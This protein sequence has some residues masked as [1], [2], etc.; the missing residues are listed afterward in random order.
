MSRSGFAIFTVIAAT[1]VLG[2]ISGRSVA[3]HSK[4][5]A[6]STPGAIIANRNSH[7]MSPANEVTARPESITACCAA[8]CIGG[9]KCGIYCEE[10]TVNDSCEARYRFDCPQGEA[11]VCQGGSCICAH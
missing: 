8:A 7:E 1:L 11:L 4:K 10:I 2:A 5:L 6:D 9:G 3:E